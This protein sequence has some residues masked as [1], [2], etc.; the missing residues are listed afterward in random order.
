MQNKVEMKEKWMIKVGHP[1][2][3]YAKP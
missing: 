2:E 1:M 3:L